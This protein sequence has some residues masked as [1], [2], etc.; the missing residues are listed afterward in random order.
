MRRTL[1]NAGAIPV[2]LF[3]KRERTMNMTLEPTGQF[4][5]LTGEVLCRAWEG[6]TDKGEDIMAL[7]SVVQTKAEM[8]AL[9]P[10]PPPEPTWSPTVRAAMG[11]LWQLAGKLL[12]EE[13][14]AIVEFIEHIT[15]LV[16]DEEG[17]REAA[18]EFL[19]QAALDG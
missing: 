12:D 16:D 1:A 3:E 10:V 14:A 2:R 18:E 17:R 5:T 11:R 9:T 8:P 19:R 6:K 15:S 13:A 4:V 7:V